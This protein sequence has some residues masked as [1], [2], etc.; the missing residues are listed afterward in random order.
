MKFVLVS[1]WLAGIFF[2]ELSL[3]NLLQE[4]LAL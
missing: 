1:D 3:N 2:K 4:Y